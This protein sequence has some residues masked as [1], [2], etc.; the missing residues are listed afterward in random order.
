MKTFFDAS[1]LVS[2]LN[3]S[4]PHH[5]E[6]TKHWIKCEQ[7]ATSCHAL[8]ECYRTLTTLKQPLRPE[9]A[10]AALNEL[11]TKIE[12][13]TG[14]PDIY[15]ATKAEQWQRFTLAFGER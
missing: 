6:A 13:V 5:A 1:V 7:R 12:L 4:S 11:Q 15:V 14:T 10:R 3:K 9:D 2:L 8:A